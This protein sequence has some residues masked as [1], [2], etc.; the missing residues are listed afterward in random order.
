MRR[1]D[2]DLRDPETNQKKK[3]LPPVLSIKNSH[4]EDKQTVSSCEEIK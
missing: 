2:C 3:M 4:K 1:D